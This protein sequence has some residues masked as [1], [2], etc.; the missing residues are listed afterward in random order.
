MMFELDEAGR[1]ELL[2]YDEKP[3]LVDIASSV[4]KPGESEPLPSGGAPSDPTAG[5]ATVKTMLARLYFIPEG[6]VD[7]DGD[8][9]Q[10]SV[11]IGFIP[12]G[13]QAPSKC[14]HR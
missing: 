9:T 1:L 7:E 8:H 13:D 10:T 2:I 11:H 5:A 12:G 3:Q 14:W 6:E 4:E